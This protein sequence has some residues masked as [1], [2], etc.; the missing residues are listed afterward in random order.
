MHGHEGQIK[1]NREAAARARRLVHE[2]VRPDDRERVLK[3]AAELDAQA[4]ALERA[5]AER[6]A[7]P[8]VT[9]TQ[10]QAQQGPPS[11]D[12]PPEE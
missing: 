8:Q 6:P 1:A 5:L 2:F 7:A 10:M 12:D 3:F 4:D 9:Q 11:R